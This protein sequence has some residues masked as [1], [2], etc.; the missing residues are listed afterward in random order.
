MSMAL[1]VDDDEPE[2]G[3][4]LL[5]EVESGGTLSSLFTILS[6]FT[7]D[8]KLRYEEEDG[9]ASHA[10]HRD[11]PPH[12]RL[13]TQ[14]RPSR[15]SQ[16][17]NGSR[18]LRTLSRLKAASS[19]SEATVTVDADDSDYISSDPETDTRPDRPEPVRGNS[20]ASPRPSSRASSGRATPSWR[21]QREYGGINTPPRENTIAR[22]AVDTTLA[23]IPAE[24]FRRLTK[25][26]P[27]AAAHIVQGKYKEQA[28]STL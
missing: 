15:P 10:G 8:V 25:K 19:S 9:E 2:S 6:L 13:D 26:F 16:S 22:A 18:H 20:S 4:Q 21:A 5:N 7:E 23:V 27:N 24:A 11:E 28:L 3:I 1:D 14:R 12:F 17:R